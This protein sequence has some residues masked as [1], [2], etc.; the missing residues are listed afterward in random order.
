MN[1]QYPAF[2]ASPDAISDDAVIE[3]KCP[4]SKETI[5]KYYYRIGRMNNKVK[6]QLHMQMIFAKKCRGYL[7]IADPDFEN[8]KQFICIVRILDEEFI[9]SV[10]KRA[11]SFWEKC[12]FPIL[13]K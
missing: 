1:Q 8:N 9:N 4:K 7:C 6:A 2:G 11:Q 10:M 12:I 3:V 13:M 5:E